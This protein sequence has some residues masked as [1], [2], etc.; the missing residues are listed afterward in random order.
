MYEWVEK[1]QLS[2]SLLLKPKPTLYILYA[3]FDM[4]VYIF[5][6][7]IIV[8]LVLVAQ[9]IV[10]ILWFTMQNQVFTYQYTF[11]LNVSL[12]IVNITDKN[13]RRTLFKMRFVIYWSCT[14]KYVLLLVLICSFKNHQP[15]SFERTKTLVVLLG[16]Y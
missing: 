8:L 15:L 2:V 14:L 4:C 10:I 3:N 9:I 5:Q 7:A 12:S 13:P 16:N 11:F 1:K 6:Y